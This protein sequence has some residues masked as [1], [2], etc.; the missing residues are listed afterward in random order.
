M[1]M[2]VIYVL[3]AIIQLNGKEK[4]E[5]C[6]VLILRYSLILISEEGIFAVPHTSKCF[7]IE[8]IYIKLSLNVS[9]LTYLNHLYS[10]HRTQSVF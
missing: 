6:L 8:E 5:F 9:F 2:K 1:L 10:V 7:S 4:K 3:D